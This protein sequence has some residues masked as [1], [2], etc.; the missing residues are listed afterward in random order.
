[1]TAMIQKEKINW[2]YSTVIPLVSFHVFALFAVFPQLFSWYN[3]IASILLLQITGGFGI[4]IGYHRMLSHRAFR[5]VH[6]IFGFFH[7]LCG[8]L[9]LQMGPISW[10]RIHRHH[11]KHT[12][13]PQDPHDQNKGF[14]HV[15]IGW[16]L[17]KMDMNKFQQPT[18]LE[19]IWY[20]KFMEKNF[21][22]I[23]TIFLLGLFGLGYYIGANDPLNFESAEYMA[24]HSAV[25][26]GLIGGTGMLVWAGFVRII[27][28]YNLT[29]CINSVCHRFGYKNFE[30]DGS[31]GTSKNNY[32]IGYFSFGE[33]WHNNHHAFPTSAKQGLLPWQVDMSY[34]LILILKFLG[35]AWN[36]KVPTPEMIEK[37]KAHS[38]LILEPEALPAL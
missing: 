23:N 22:Y 16:M 34:G 26:H 4:S 9:A 36:V 8:T 3:F 1:M 15:H 32:F 12:D 25:H 33:G 35:L 19:K 20:V 11:H 18:D 30:V 21:V 38:G 31:T 14:F 28:L 27:V 17:E 7:T 37:R 6:P 29:W 13:T 24:A 5:D 2:D 10:S